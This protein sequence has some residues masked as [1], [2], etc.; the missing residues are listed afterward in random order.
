[1]VRTF[2]MPLVFLLSLRR[3]YFLKLFLVISNFDHK[4]LS[5]L[6]EPIGKQLSFW[7][8]NK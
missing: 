7:S 8:H 2:Q 4:D 1:M 6:S 5:K 3:I